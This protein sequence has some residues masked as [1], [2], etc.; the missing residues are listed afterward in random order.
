MKISR[1][2]ASAY[3]NWCSAVTWSVNILTATVCTPVRIALYTWSGNVPGESLRHM[4]QQSRRGN[5]SEQAT[6]LNRLPAKTGN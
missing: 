4:R 5:F 6:C 3:R 1:R 2:K